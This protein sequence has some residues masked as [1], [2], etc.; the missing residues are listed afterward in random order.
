MT[1]A[2]IAALNHLLASANWARHRLQPFTAKTA[3]FVVPPLQI[4]LAINPEAYFTHADDPAVVPD[5]VIRLPA[6]T[7]F[8]MLQGIE[9]V[10]SAAHVEGNA[11]FATE[12]SFVLHHLRWDAEQD[13]AR[14]L[15]DIPARR[16]ATEAQRFLAWQT[17]LAENLHGNI[18]EYLAHENPLLLTRTEFSAFQSDMQQLNARLERIDSRCK[19]L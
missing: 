6:D 3:C 1:G 11:E 15:G 10:M 14:L 19:L 2:L 17:Q 16:I 4:V 5:V 12:L 7:P 13:L 8:L 18:A 9:R